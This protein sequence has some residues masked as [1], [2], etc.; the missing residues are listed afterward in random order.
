MRKL[1]RTFFRLLAFNL[2]VALT[3][4]G[5]SVTGQ[6]ATEPTGYIAY[7]GLDNNIYVY[8][9]SDQLTTSV[10]QDA[11]STRR[12]Q[13]PTWSTDGR[14]AYFCCA[15][16]GGS[17]PV[18]EAHVF[19][20]DSFAPRMI[21]QEMG[22]AFTYGYWAPANNCLQG[23][24]CRQLAVLVSQA[25]AGEFKV[26]LIQDHEDDPETL[27]HVNIGTGAPFYFSWSPDGSQMAWQRNNRFLDIYQVEKNAVVDT[28]EL[29]NAGFPAPMWSPVDERVLFAGRDTDS[30]A[31]NL[32]TVE[33][34]NRTRLTEDVGG[35]VAFNWSPDG[36]YIAYR[37]VQSNGYGN[38]EVI[39]ALTGTS[40]ASGRDDAIAF[41]W[42]PDS[43]KIAYVSLIEISRSQSAVFDPFQQGESEFA[44]AWAVLSVAD[45]STDYFANFIPTPEMVY[46]LTYFDQFAQSHR[47]WSPDSRYLVYGEFLEDGDAQVTILDTDDE[48]A[49]PFSIAEGTL[50]IWSY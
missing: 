37:E 14:L 20:P 23:E 12:Y 24:A 5:Y 8:D 46:I 25:T 30:N 4:V 16:G 36:R 13:Y 38:V 28:V 31:L 43:S 47:F 41:F 33:A 21:Y 10:T 18:L 49:L 45:S 39:D 48:S 44:L 3:A 32:T 6:G 15:P 34:L 11:D 50:G 35:F 17:V 22:E 1:K 27:G 26:E 9:F 42:S 29:D 19:R 7:I 2:L 40:V